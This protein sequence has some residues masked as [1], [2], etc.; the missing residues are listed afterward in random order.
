[1][2]W[3]KLWGAVWWASEWSGVGLGRWAPWV[4]S[5]MLGAKRR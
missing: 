1:M 5:Q 4:L 2:L 3:R